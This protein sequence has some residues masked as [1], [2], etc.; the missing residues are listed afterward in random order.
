MWG[1]RYIYLSDQT[2]A[3]A[4]GYYYGEALSIGPRLS[5]VPGGPTGTKRDTV[6]R[7][8]IY[9]GREIDTYIPQQ[10]GHIFANGLELAIL[11]FLSFP[12]I[13]T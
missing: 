2:K 8:S 7:Q 10:S 13:F 6:L 1:D 4:K 5:A 9:L 12:D 11:W 3:L